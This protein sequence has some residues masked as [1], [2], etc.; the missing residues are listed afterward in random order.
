[1]RA[2][3]ATAS[4]PAVIGLMAGATVGC[5]SSDTSTPATTST[6]TTTTTASNR[7]V[8]FDTPDGQVSVSLDGKLPPN[9]PTAFPVAPGATPAGSGSLGNS[10]KTVMVGVYS[11]SGSA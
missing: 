7:T 4:A 8:A 11:V 1:M 2:R 9:W 3:I 6:S 10:D 5:S